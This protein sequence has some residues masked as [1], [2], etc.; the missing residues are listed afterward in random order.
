MLEVATNN[1]TLLKKAFGTVGPKR[2]FYSAP[3]TVDMHFDLGHLTE[4]IG[5]NPLLMDMYEKTLITPTNKVSFLYSDFDNNGKRY[6]TI[7]NLL[8]HNS[9][10]IVIT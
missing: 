4:P 5:L 9:G 1:A 8:E 2:G 3:V 6:I 7:Q 10:K